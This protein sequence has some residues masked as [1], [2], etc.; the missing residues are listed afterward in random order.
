MLMSLKL[1]LSF[2][3]SGGNFA[4]IYFL[5][6]CY[7]LSS[8][9]LHDLMTGLVESANYYCLKVTPLQQETS[10][11]AVLQWRVSLKTNTE[12]LGLCRDVCQQL[13]I[14]SRPYPQHKHVP[15]SGHKGTIFHLQG[16]NKS[17]HNNHPRWRLTVEHLFISI[18]WGLFCGRLSDDVDPT[19]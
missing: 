9:I 13:L 3:L 4:R 19:I 1:S 14:K 8:I 17:I 2:K 10:P 16:A 12:A 7:K 15:R 6:A 5:H 18:H 11:A